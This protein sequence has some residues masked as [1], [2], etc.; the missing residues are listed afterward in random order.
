MIQD[1]VYIEK[2]LAWQECARMRVFLFFVALLSCWLICCCITYLLFMAW[3]GF[4]GW[5]V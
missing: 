3:S 2:H 1:I 4:F 5:I